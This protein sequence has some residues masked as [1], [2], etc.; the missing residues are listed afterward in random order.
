M[1]IDR[2]ANA[3][4]AVEATAATSTATTASSA[5]TTSP[6]DC[7]A[8]ERPAQAPGCMADCCSGRKQAPHTTL[9]SSLMIMVV[10]ADVGLVEI[11][12]LVE[13]RC[14]F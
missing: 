6:A 1:T 7:G 4:A 9:S 8:G 14:K 13:L 3:A 2:L 12:L 5:K 11:Q 10:D